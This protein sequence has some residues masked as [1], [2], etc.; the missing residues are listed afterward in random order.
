LILGCQ[1][2]KPN[3]ILPEKH[4]WEIDNWEGLLPDSL[5]LT[6]EE[7]LIPN[8]DTAFI[9][10]LNNKNNR[11]DIRSL[12]SENFEDLKCLKQYLNGKSL[13]QLGES[14]HGTKEY[15]QIKVRLIKFLHEEM[16]FDVIAF[17]SGFFEC[18][19]T[20]KNLNNYTAKEALNNSIFKFVWG[21]EEVLEL[22]EYIEQTQSTEHPLILTGFDCQRSGANYD[23]RPDVLFDMLSKIDTLYAEDVLTFDHYVLT[24]GLY[25][26][27]YLVSNEDSIKSK[28]LEII[29]TIDQHIVQLINYYPDQEHYPIFIKQSINSTLA[30]VMHRIAYY[31]NNGVEQYF[32]RDSAMAANISFLKEEL[33]P[34][35]KIIIWAHNYHIAHDPDHQ[36]WYSNAKNMGNWLVEKYRDELYTIGLYMLR[37]KTRTD[38]DW[39]II[40]VELPTTSY[41]LE[42]ILYHERKKYLFVDVLNHHYS[43]GNKWMYYTITAKSSG[44]A[45]EEMII[46]D[47][48]DG[49]IFIDTSS[50]PDY[51][52]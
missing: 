46:K 2:D 14:S 20:Y 23:K 41:S 16:G 6:Q 32:V 52:N 42:S 1:K 5:L 36:A 43:E 9:N 45:D 7:T 35:K 40:D 19:Y 47:E 30:E 8:V 44:F 38:Y 17:E 49:I 11:I 48:Y 15:N 21:T 28:Y 51:L 12:T 13:V 10:W 4:C 37:G 33:F 39:S 50:V 26:Y 29:S 22:F 34:D 18:Y 3:Q 31:E 25:N 27:N 24:T